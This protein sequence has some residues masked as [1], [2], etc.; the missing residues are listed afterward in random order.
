MGI[1]WIVDIVVKWAKDNG[2][3][4]E[5]EQGL[6]GKHYIVFKK[7]WVKIKLFDHD[8]LI[9]WTRKNVEGIEVSEELDI[10]MEGGEVKIRQTI[11]S[12]VI[13]YYDPEKFA[14]VSK[15]IIEWLEGLK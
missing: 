5:V 6:F 4:E 7:G 15:K 13:K 1:D 12:E 14:D 8:L 9:Y 10:S 3:S 2:F 11:Y